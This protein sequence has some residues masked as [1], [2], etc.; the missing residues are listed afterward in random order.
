MQIEIFIMIIY[1]ERPQLIPIK[2]KLDRREAAR[3]R[4]A[5][6]AARLEKSIE[7]ELIERLKNKA[8]GDAPLNVND[9]IWQKILDQDVE[10]AEDEESEEDDE[11][12]VEEEEE[13]EDEVK[14][15]ACAVVRLWDT[16]Y[17]SL[18]LVGA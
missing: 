5:E 2:K 6:A 17:R 1:S 13:D 4:K 16:Y 18:F 12:E 3:E 8:Y 7:K 14:V 11:N 15:K 10:G 9:D